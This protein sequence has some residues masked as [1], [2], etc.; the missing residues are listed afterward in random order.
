MT[1]PQASRVRQLV[2]AYLSRGRTTRLGFDI[3]NPAHFTRLAHHVAE[4][5]AA[6]RIKPDDLAVVTAM[7]L[8]GPP[9]AGAPPR[10]ARR[11]LL[12]LVRGSAPDEAAR[13]ARVIEFAIAY[14]LG[15]WRVGGRGAWDEPWEEAR[16]ALARAIEPAVGETY[17]WLRTIVV[18]LP[19]RT[20]DELASHASRLAWR[21]IRPEKRVEIGSRGVLAITCTGSGTLVT[22][23][24]WPENK[25][26]PHG[27]RYVLGALAPAVLD[28]PQGPLDLDPGTRLVVIA[29]ELEAK[30]L[31]LVKNRMTGYRKLVLGDTAA[32]SGPT[33][34]AIWECTCGT[35][36]CH[37]RHRLAAWDPERMVTAGDDERLLSLWSFGASAVKGPLPL[38]ASTFVKGMYFP[39]LAQEGLE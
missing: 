39:F 15:K 27:A 23:P 13:L 37:L 33:A 38:R 2:R 28:M 19:Q 34:L 36:T 17:R 21:L 29:K 24:G 35:E 4:H 25:L 5:L 18:A 1:D 22:V 3:G 10:R 8:L 30:I 20:R 12:A 16:G 9:T 14:G 6:P 11:D 32:V 7:C 31:V 26:V